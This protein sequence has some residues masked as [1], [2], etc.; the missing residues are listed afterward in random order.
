MSSF[1]CHFNSLAKIERF[2]REDSQIDF[3]ANNVKWGWGVLRVDVINLKI[4]LKTCKMIPCG[5]NNL[6]CGSIIV[7]NLLNL[8]MGMI[9][10]ATDG[11]RIAQFYR[12][13]GRGGSGQAP[14]PINF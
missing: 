13:K 12:I 2:L 5:S 10:P 1:T 8:G 6:A 7:A 3:T 14:Q 9:L 4:N 11:K